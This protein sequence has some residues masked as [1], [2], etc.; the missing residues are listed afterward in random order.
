MIP[1]ELGSCYTQEDWGMKLVHFEEFVEKFI[2]KKSDHVGYLAQHQLFDQI[3]ELKKDICIPEYCCLSEAEDSACEP[4]INA[5]F[6][7]AGT[8]SPLHYD[9]KHNLL[10]QVFG[11]KRVLL[12]PPKDSENL[13]PHETTMLFNT[14]QVDPYCPDYEM[15]PKFKSTHAIECHLYP[16][17]MLYIPPKWW[18]H[19]RSLDT[20][21]SVS[22]WWE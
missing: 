11:R 14:A 4:D 17:E 15:Y 1:I 10:C 13:Y 19:V 8:V 5:W 3:P 16:G 6:G 21:F 22:F 20:S 9:P 18:H 2:V 12:Y 7:P